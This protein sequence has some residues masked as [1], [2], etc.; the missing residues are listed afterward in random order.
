MAILQ[1]MNYPNDYPSGHNLKICLVDE[2]VHGGDYTLCG[3]AISD[4]TISFEGAEAVGKECVGSV[5]DVT[6]PLCKS[7]LKYLKSLK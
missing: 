7:R 6:C 3:N 4:S 5:K 2:S 1:V